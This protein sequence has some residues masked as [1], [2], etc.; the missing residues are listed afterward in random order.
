M[1]AALEH[2]GPDDSGVHSIPDGGPVL[3]HQRLSILDLS[4]LGHQPMQS[5]CGRLW[6]VYNGEVYNF[7]EIRQELEQ[8]QHRFNSDS[9]TEVILAAYAQWG[10]A[11]VSRF[12]GMFAFALWD[13]AAKR[14]H[15]CR[16]RFGV[17][18][19]YYARSHQLLAFAS[20]P[21][22]L[23]RVRLTR[24]EVDPAALCEYVQ[25]GYVSAPKSLY[26]ALRTVR[27]G[28]VLTFDPALEVTESRYW[29]ASKLYSAAEV[30][31]ASEAL[32]AMSEAELLERV[33]SELSEAF[34]YRLVS[35][36]PVGL[37]LSG[38]I[39]SS[40]VAALLS[41]VPGTT[42]RTFT[43][44]YAGSEFD[45]SKYARLVATH[46]GAQHTE[47]TV[48]E[49]EA[50]ALFSRLNDIADEP[51]GDSSLVPTLMVSE[52][53]RRHVKVA[54]SGDG[55]DELFG[56]YAR[57]AACARYASHNGALVRA[58]RWLSAEVLSALPPQW[59]AAGYRLARGEH[60][61]FAGIEDKLRKFINL[62]RAQDTFSGYRA[63]VSEWTPRQS[64]E[65]GVHSSEFEADLAQAFQAADC[66]DDASRYMHFDLTRYLP[67]DLL[68]KVDR[69]SMAVSLEAR[70]PF[71]DHKLAALAIALPL[72]WKLRQGQ[73]KYILRR[74]LDRHYPAGLFDRPK[75]G[76][77]APVGK[78]LRGPLRGVLEE[79]LAP[80]RVREFG[81]LD[82][83]AVQ[84]AVSEFLAGGRSTSTSGMWFLLQ[85]QRWAG[86]WLRSGA[87][88]SVDTTA[89]RLGRVADIA[90]SS[91]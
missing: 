32:R 59:I 37:F 74:L 45:E 16:D 10:L 11:A 22:A 79:E 89:E 15:L 73:N 83:D 54:L 63:T 5:A 91:P 51:I 28:T 21:K 17:K 76:F 53:A 58:F 77:S 27:P 46:L 38:G 82:A 7:R 81:L 4:A 41:R 71:L 57:Y 52:L 66:V 88:P 20:E 72:E 85:L 6:I 60:Q 1:T 50:L 44:G 48:S 24:S 87:Q 35:D 2:R 86:R 19:L 61:R 69:A 42:L 12:R 43:I 56:G 75:H 14:L 9:D 18:P 84:R 30:R 40:I 8:R 39:D 34:Q 68:T 3:G 36:V 70:E 65:L 29:S 62:S 67:G 49:E 55:A 25:F 64:S 31:P 23:H 33:E 13:G 90:S 80:R 47:F 78:W 26:A